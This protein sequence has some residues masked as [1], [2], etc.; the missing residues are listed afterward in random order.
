M[1]PGDAVR[2]ML[3]S[4]AGNAGVLNLGV[5][6]NWVMCCVSRASLALT[7]RGFDLE[8]HV[9][10]LAWTC[11]MLLAAWLAVGRAPAALWAATGWPPLLNAPTANVS[12]SR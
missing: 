8:N 5:A 7:L 3:P 9:L 12:E 4:F 11:A 2:L 6:W 10:W 1:G